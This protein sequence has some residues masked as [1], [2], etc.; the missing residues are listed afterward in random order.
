LPLSGNLFDEVLARHARAVDRTICYRQLVDNA[1]FRKLPSTPC[2][3]RLP[4]LAA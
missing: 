1:P 4:G 2:L 3:D